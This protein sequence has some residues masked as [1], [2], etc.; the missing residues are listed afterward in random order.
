M[1]YP[2]IESIVSMEMPDMTR[3]A[4]TYMAELPS[5]ALH[6]LEELILREIDRQQGKDTAQLLRDTSVNHNIIPNAFRFSTLYTPMTTGT[7][8]PQVAMEVLR[9][10]D[11]VIDFNLG[12]NHGRDS[13]FPAMWRFCCDNP[14]RLKPFLMEP[15]TAGVR[16]KEIAIEWLGAVCAAAK[17]RATEDS[18][19]TKAAAIKGECNKIFCEVL[20]AYMDD[21][22]RGEIRKKEIISILMG[23]AGAAGADS[24]RQFIPKLYQCGM[25]D[26][27]I[28]G[29]QED[30]AWSF[31][32]GWEPSL[33]ELNTYSL[34]FSPHALPHQQG[35]DQQIPRKV[36]PQEIEIN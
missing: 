14:E 35:I 10:K 12:D 3:R 18:G 31:T 11:D 19:D 15:L 23:E 21:F 4:Y 17:H 8:F 20:Q 13:I 34:F 33:P 1:K 32:L 26:E 16:G 29:T 30:L 22:Q 2:K 7:E 28:C 9:Q 24:V 27:D 36:L 6:D 5:D 25:I